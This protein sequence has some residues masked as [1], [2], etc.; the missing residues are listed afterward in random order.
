MVVSDALTSDPSAHWT[1]R[2]DAFQ[3][4][5]ELCTLAKGQQYSTRDTF[6]K[7]LVNHSL[8]QYACP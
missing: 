7:T 2:R 6:Y 8:L 3:F 4:L 5:Q 1:D